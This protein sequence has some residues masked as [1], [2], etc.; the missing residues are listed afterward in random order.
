MAV[1]AFKTI[2]ST[3]INDIV[4]L[5]ASGNTFV[6]S[7]VGTTGYT[8]TFQHQDWVDF[9]DPVAAGGSNGFNERFHALE[10]EFDLIATAIASADTAIGQIEQAPPAIGMVVAPGISNGAKIPVPANFD[11]SQTK[12]F[13]FPKLYTSTVSALGQVVGFTVA[14]AAD[15]TVTATAQ[16][17]TI[18]AT[19]IAIAK[20]G[21]W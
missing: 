7:Q 5:V 15:G 14:A 20:M 12:F 16:S 9:V 19:G 1:M 17:G 4:K 11:V 13:A 6:V 21:G 10:H 8:R 18:V 2:D 3:N